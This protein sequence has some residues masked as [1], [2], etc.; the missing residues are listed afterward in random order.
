MTYEGRIAQQESNMPAIETVIP[1]NSGMAFV[2]KKGRVLRVIGEST[3]DFVVFNLRDVRERFDQARTKVDQGKIYVSTGDVLISK[4]NNVMMTIVKDTYRGT[5]DMEKGMCSTSFYKKWGDKIFAI[6]GATWKKLGRKKVV[7]PKHGCWENLAKAL[8]PY[9]VAKEDVPSPLNIFQTMVING[10]TGSMRYA[11]IRP[12]PGGD[13][14]DLRAEMDCL[15][16]ISACPEGG[17]GKELRVIV[18]D[19]QPRPVRGSRQ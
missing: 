9:K 4:F 12:R 15:V 2:V 5:H 19:R 14:M 7:A 6:Y 18:Y 1:K 16:G 8:K 13:R 10:K 11:M 17:R 3:A